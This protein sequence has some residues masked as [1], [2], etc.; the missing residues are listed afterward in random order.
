MTTP[1]V[2]PG[3]TTQDWGGRI[4]PPD[5][6]NQIINLLVGGS[7]FANSLTR[8]PTSRPSV[9]YPTAQPSGLAW[10]AELEEFPRIDLADDAVVVGIKKL[11][12]LVDLSNE[13]VSDSSFNIT[14]A[15]QQL[16]GDGLSRDLDLGLLYGSGADNEPAGVV[17]N[18]PSVAGATLLTAVSQAIGEIGD[19][20]G[21]ANTIA[22]SAAALADANATTA[23]D[24]QLV[25]PNGFATAVGLNPVVVPE[26]STPLVYDNTRCY[27]VL[28]GNE[29]EVAVS[30]DWRFSFDATS[31]RIK[32]RAAVA[33]PAPQRSIRKLEVG[34]EGRK[35][36]PAPTKPAPAK[37]TT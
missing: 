28:N 6:R 18:A 1:V 14:A 33:I 15:L 2:L 35:A 12:G 26:L 13:L 29:S 19:A 10:L 36:V 20:G 30:T 5:V 4:A 21:S 24:G 23:T 32:V 3:L 31:I 11:G 22:A 37:K 7:P 27:L 16:L 8:D 17:P 34:S 25:Y 9:A